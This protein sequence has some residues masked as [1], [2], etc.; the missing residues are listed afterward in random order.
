M[1]R[2]SS[3]HPYQYYASDKLLSLE[4]V[5]T[6]QVLNIKNETDKYQSIVTYFPGQTLPVGYKLQISL[7]FSGVNK[8]NTQS[9]RI[10]SFDS[11][12]VRPDVGKKDPISNGAEK[13]SENGPWKNYVGSL[14][15][16]KPD[17]GGI[18]L[19]RREAGEDSY[20]VNS[21]SAD[22][23]TELG[24]E[25]TVNNGRALKPIPDGFQ[26]LK[27]EDTYTMTLEFVN[28][29]AGISQSM[30]IKSVTG[31]DI[32]FRSTFFDHDGSSRFDTLA[33]GI[34]PSVQALKIQNLIIKTISPKPSFDALP[35]QDRLIFIGDSIT[36]GWTKARI[37][38]PLN[39]TSQEV[40]DPRGIWNKY[41]VPYHPLNLGVSGDT[42]QDVL[43]R[44]GTFK[45]GKG[46]ELDGL[47]YSTKT[48]VLL[49]GTN[50]IDESVQNITEGIGKTISV[51]KERLP[52][53][54]I[55]LLGILHRYDKKFI[56]DSNGNSTGEL[57]NDRISTVNGKLDYCTNHSSEEKCKNFKNVKF[58]STDTVGGDSLADGLHPTV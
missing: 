19:Y 11:R 46:G 18:N 33:L 44:I 10:G 7:N 3:V 57:V 34:P 58:I 15:T 12:G 27:K 54:K 40:V 20:L 13:N 5:G 32:R 8:T 14:M 24:G 6:T 42:I 53:A 52:N 2:D 56:K 48:V 17:T 25:N 35:P 29:G 21:V 23:Y 30:E 41:F 49:I 55:I 39:T 22:S 31:P 4:K 9:L 26:G 47:D 45:N 36:A 37:R 43:T 51:I 28:T 1:S 38:T 16:F 50:S